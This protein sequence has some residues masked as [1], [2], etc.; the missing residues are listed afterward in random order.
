[1]LAAVNTTWAKRRES[2]L[3][4]GL[5]DFMLTSLT[6]HR[7]VGD[8]AYDSD[9]ANLTASQRSSQRPEKCMRVGKMR[10]GRY[11]HRHQRR[12]AMESAISSFQNFRRLCT[13]QG[14]VHQAFQGLPSP[15]LLHHAPQEVL[16]RL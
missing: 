3:V 6:H 15:L 8:Q 5:F 12:R 10:D 7:V 11:L 1:M 13:P 2:K 16:D 9:G 14:E 4:Q